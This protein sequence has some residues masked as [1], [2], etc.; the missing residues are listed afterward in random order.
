[1]LFALYINENFL[2]FQDYAK[3][4]TAGIVNNYCREVGNNFLPLFGRS[5][6]LNPIEH[7]WD[8]LK[9]HIIPRNHQSCW[10]SKRMNGRTFLKPVSSGQC[11]W[12]WKLL[13]YQEEVL[14][15]IKIVKN[16]YFFK[17]QFHWFVIYSHIKTICNIFIALFIIYPSNVNQVT[18]KLPL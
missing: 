6:K 7:V 15:D 9:R 4:H 14:P 10:V 18:N 5:P 1:M 17:Y 16:I 12:A 13:D 8:M 3:S 11:Q 2:C